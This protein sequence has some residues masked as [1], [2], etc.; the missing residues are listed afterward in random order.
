MQRQEKEITKVEGT[1]ERKEDGGTSNKSK[2]A[3]E[4]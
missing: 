4:F 3:S 2:R 1:E